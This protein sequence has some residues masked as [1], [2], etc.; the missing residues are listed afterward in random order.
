[1]AVTEEMDIHTYWHLQAIEIIS[2]LSRGL[3]DAPK[4]PTSF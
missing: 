2:D 4:F 1:V 3:S